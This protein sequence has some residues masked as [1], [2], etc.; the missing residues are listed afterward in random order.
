[1]IFKTPVVFEDTLSLSCT[2]QVKSL[3]FFL[4]FFFSSFTSRYLAKRGP[5]DHQQPGVGFRWNRKIQVFQT[6]DSGTIVEHR[7][8][9]LS[10]QKSVTQHSLFC[11]HLTKLLNC[12]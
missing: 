2:V 1:M 12:D 8:N 3:L 9:I 4:F 7:V 5:L 10:G 11:T 6:A